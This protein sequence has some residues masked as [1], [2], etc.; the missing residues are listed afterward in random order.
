MASYRLM[1]RM[2]RL[3]AF[4]SVALMTVNS[5]AQSG[6][7]SG[8]K[9]Y[10][11]GKCRYPD[12]IVQLKRQ[13][14]ANAA[15]KAAEEARRAEA[16]RRRR[17]VEESEAV[18][19]AEQI[20]IADNKRNREA[21]DVPPEDNVESSLRARISQQMSEISE[22]RAQINELKGTTDKVACLIARVSESAEA[23]ETYDRVIAS[24]QCKQLARERVA[25]L[26]ACHLARGNGSAEAWTR[27]LGDHPTGACADQAQRQVAATERRKSARASVLKLG[28][29]TLGIGSGVMAVGLATLT[30]PA[31]NQ[32][33][34]ALGPLLMGTGLGMVTSGLFVLLVA[35][36]TEADGF[37]DETKRTAFRP[38]VSPNYIGIHGRF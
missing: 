25:D 6:Q 15:A 1:N 17:E 18:D 2:V 5:S 21:L 31:A 30:K 22:Q 7:C 32:E 38:I 28:G 16:L 33:D 36:A 8:T 37:E 14:F 24:G 10:Y 27:Y 34:S 29:W 12:D 3:V 26:S 13:E 11:A 9:Q 23:W 19:A 4:V 20:R 35:P